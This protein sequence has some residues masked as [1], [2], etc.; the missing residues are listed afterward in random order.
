MSANT[1]LEL[2]SVNCIS[3]GASLDGFENKKEMKCSYCDTINKFLKPAS[4]DRKAAKKNLNSE[5]FSKFENLCEILE[6]AMTAGN[7]QEGYDYCN[8][9]LELD[10]KSAELWGNK[11]ICAFWKSATII[12]EDKIS[13]TNA[14]EIVTFLKSSKELENGEYYEDTA[15][16][17]SSNLSILTIYKLKNLSLNNALGTMVGIGKNAQF[18][19]D[20]HLTSNAGLVRDYFDLIET[21][22]EIGVKKNPEYIKELVPILMGHGCFNN[23]GEAKV[24]QFVLPKNIFTKITPAAYLLSKLGEVSKI[25]PFQRLKKLE[26]TIKSVEPSWNNPHVWVQ[27]SSVFAIIAIVFFVLIFLWTFIT[28]L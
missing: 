5:Q 13:N 1:T 7:Y 8:K 26:V 3:C 2:Q 9:A 20:P 4:V 22:F 27:K 12:G 24:Y 11:A 15:N 25:H 6:K 19:S 16:S 17:I 18:T 28:V 23:Q 21:A 14:R 10:P